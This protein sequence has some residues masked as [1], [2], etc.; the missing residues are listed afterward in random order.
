MTQLITIGNQLANALG[1]MVLGPLTGWPAALSL[2]VIAV[3]TGVIMLVVYKYTSPQ[4][5]IQRTRARIK[6]NL[7]ALS[8]FKDDLRVC[9]LAI[10]RVLGGATI[11]VAYA[12][13]PMLVMLVP[14]LLLLG[15]LSLWYQARP[16]LAG[17]E[18]ILTMQMRPD[19]PPDATVSLEPHSAISANLGPVR[20]AS[21]NQV[22]FRLQASIPG[23]HELRLN[24]GGTTVTKQIAVGQHSHETPRVSLLRPAMD[25]Q[26]A[27]LHPA[28]GPFS[29]DSPVQWIS[30]DYPPRL[31][32]ISGTRTWLISWFV[33]SLVAAWLL[34]KPLR[35]NL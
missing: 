24:V 33:I 17:E 6:A 5:A 35:V 31:S 19:V 12:V 27:L 16:L 21:Q 7:L 23:Q 32:W 2:A 9:L 28:E 25:W 3:V 4:A 18:V 20:V 30:I 10:L 14:T 11:S 22:C 15:Q 13:V 8:L 1:Q 29:P 34:S 26:T